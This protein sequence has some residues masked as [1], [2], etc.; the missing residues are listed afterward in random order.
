MLVLSRKT[1]EKLQ[2]GDNI[3]VTV[4]RVQG[5]KIRLGI[6]APAEVRV[7]R[8]ELTP[9]PQ[10]ASTPQTPHPATSPTTQHPPQVSGGQSG[11]GQLSS[12]AKAIVARMLENS[13]RIS[14]SEVAG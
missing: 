8:G 13:A 10:D 3:T 11:G 12:R 7:M 5:N 14:K 4:L 9:H 6:E 1:D 2:I